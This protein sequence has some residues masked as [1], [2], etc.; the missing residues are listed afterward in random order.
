MVGVAA[1]GLYPAE[2]H[3]GWDRHGPH[4]PQMHSKRQRWRNVP[5]RRQCISSPHS[6]GINF[7]ISG[8]GGITILISVSRCRDFSKLRE[9]AALPPAGFVGFVVSSQVP[10]SVRGAPVD[11]VLR[12]PPRFLAVAERQR[13]QFNGGRGRL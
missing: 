1:M 13:G 7:R 12:E 8:G 6:Q 9:P 5:D 2:H 4:L 10:G 3:S 11:L